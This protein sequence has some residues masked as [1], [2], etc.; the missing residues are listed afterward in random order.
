M[1]QFKTLTEPWKTTDSSTFAVAMQTFDQRLAAKVKAAFCAALEKKLPEIWSA[2]RNAAFTF[3]IGAPK[4]AC[5]NTHRHGFEK[6]PSHCFAE[7]SVEKQRMLH[8]APSPE[9][10]GRGEGPPAE[11]LVVTICVGGNIHRS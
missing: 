6:E 11:F 7:R 5:C 1:T 4:W 2:A 10:E 9:G 8:R 3:A